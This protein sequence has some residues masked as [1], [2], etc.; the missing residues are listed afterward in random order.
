MGSASSRSPEQR[1]LAVM[2]K[3]L[4]NVVKDATPP[5]GMR[6]PLSERT[7]ED[8]RHCFALISAREQELARQAGIEIKERP[9]FGD[10]PH[11][12]KVVP[13]NQVGRTKPGDEEG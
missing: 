10:E 5:P 1:I 2:R 11:Q 12:T 7:I 8:I 13:I 3:V 4:A 9:R 6:H